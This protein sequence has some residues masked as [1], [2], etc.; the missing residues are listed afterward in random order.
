MVQL[1]T[2]VAREIM[3]KPAIIINI[4]RNIRIVCRVI[5]VLLKWFNM[6]G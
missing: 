3:V 2:G 5:Y 6:K 4:A 1:I